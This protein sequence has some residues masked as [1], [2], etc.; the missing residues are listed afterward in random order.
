M[1]IAVSKA[2]SP[3]SSTLF[4][5]IVN[6]VLADAWLGPS[7]RV[8]YTSGFHVGLFSLTGTCSERIYSN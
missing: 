7:Y 8:I 6:I 1:S 4:Y 5:L 2:F 3:V